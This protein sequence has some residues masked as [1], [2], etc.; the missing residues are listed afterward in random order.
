MLT[1]TNATLKKLADEAA[2]MKVLLV[3]DEPISRAVALQ[4][5][6]ALGFSDIV[7]TEDGDEAWQKLL[8]DTDI[9][10]VVSD[11]KMPR[12]SGLE[13]FKACQIAFSH[14]PFVMVTANGQVE[15]VEEAID[16]GIASYLVKPFCIN[17]LGKAVSRAITRARKPRAAHPPH[18]YTR[19][20]PLVSAPDGDIATALAGE[21]HDFIDCVDDTEVDTPRGQVARMCRT[22]LQRLAEGDWTREAARE[23]KVLIESLQTLAAPAARNV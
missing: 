19:G 11:W 18:A 4:A 22:V 9:D 10:L 3:E 21:I 15:A 5:L 2:G 1:R 23:A 7:V 6:R 20:R 13:L 14:L 17:S 16:T 8:E 12:M